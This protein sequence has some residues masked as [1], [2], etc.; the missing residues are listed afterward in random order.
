MIDDVQ[1]DE[2]I[3]SADPM[4]PMRPELFNTLEVLRDEI[5]RGPVAVSGTR[6]SR[7]RRALAALCVVGVLG[8]GAGVA[9]ANGLFARTGRHATGGEDG[10]G[11]VIRVDAPDAPAVVAQLGAGLPLPPGVSID[12]VTAPFL[13]GEPTE[14]AESGLE[15]SIEFVAACKWATYWLESNTTGATAAMADAQAVLDVVPSWSALVAADG[16]GVI[17]MWRTIGDAAQAMDPVA[18]NNAGYLVNCTDVR[19]GE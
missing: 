18:L 12:D 11:E 2:L 9:A 3:A 16:G 4:R 19:P 6:P 5:T 8:A 7:R 15:A 14:Q 13:G 17:E 1:L 10:T